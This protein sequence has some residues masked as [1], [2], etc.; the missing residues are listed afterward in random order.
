MNALFLAIA[1]FAALVAPAPAGAQ[2]LTEVPTSRGQIQMS[3]APVAKAAAPAVVNVFTRKVVRSQVSPLLNDP[4]F[5]K[6][7]GDSSGSPRERI[8][9]SLGSGV[10]VDGAGLIITNHHVVAG[11]DD[12]TVVLNDRR[13]FNAELVG[14][15]QRT[16]LA[17]LRVAINGQRLPFLP[18][19]DSDALEVGDL[20][21]AIGNP[22]GVGQTVTSGIVSALARTNVGISDFQSFI[23][24]DAAINPG[25]SGGALVD[26]SG[27]L[28]GINTAIYSRDGGSNGVGFAIPTSLVR[29]VLSGLTQGGKIVRPWL[30]ASG[31]AVTADMA[32]GL[33]LGRP[34]GVVVNNIYPGSPAARAGL[35]VGDVITAI[36]SR[37]IADDVGLRFRL[38]TLA[39]GDAANLTV[40]RHGQEMHLAATLKAPPED[41]PRNVSEI[42]GRSPFT[43][44]TVANLNPALA[45]ELGIGQSQLGVVVL[46]LKRG[47]IAQRM[48][49]KAGDII[50]QVN[51][52][53]VAQ[54]DDLKRV[55]DR[56]K[57][58][59]RVSLNRDGET[60]TFTVE[61]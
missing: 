36:N 8:Q 21:L 47:S 1:L 4:F 56:A 55:A 42:G 51:G 59:W 17:V 5:R 10:I 19:G 13:E 35:K 38:A 49:F 9:Q 24:T 28:I 60:I 14:S 12:I 22:F 57:N 3:F 45:E 32:A 7:F 30:G 40:L 34:M 46:S 39:V 37:D 2:Q 18:L 58:G 27:R 16:D 44:A 43:G 33:Q 23:Q 20:V 50:L 15:D 11:A 52:S 48:N 53:S 31:Q 41:P 25:N 26:M 6:F 61:R 54:V 29:A